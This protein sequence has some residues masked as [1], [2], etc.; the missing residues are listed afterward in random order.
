MQSPTFLTHFRNTVTRLCI[1][2]NTNALKWE[3]NLFKVIPQCCIAYPYTAHDFCI[4]R[5]CKERVHLHNERNFPLAKLNTEINTRFLLNGLVHNH[6]V[7][8]ILLNLKKE[9]KHFSG[10]KKDRRKSA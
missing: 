9:L 1:K 3:K 10:R 6:S 5:G 4:I 8:I 7:H 2:D